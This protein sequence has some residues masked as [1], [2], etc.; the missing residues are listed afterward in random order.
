MLCH[1]Y[2]KFPTAVVTAKP[3]Q[4]HGSSKW[5][6]GAQ[7]K[8]AW[9]MLLFFRRLGKNISDLAE[10]GGAGGG[11]FVRLLSTNICFRSNRHIQSV[12]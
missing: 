7:R 4:L 6:A 8:P 3:L 9:A 2:T 12:Q 1:G 5:L 11:A 10:E